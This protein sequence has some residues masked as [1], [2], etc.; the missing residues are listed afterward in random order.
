MRIQYQF[1]RGTTMAMAIAMLLG[2]CGGDKPEALL[3]SA[4]D[5]LAKND[6]KAAGIQIKNAL[7][8][9]PGLALLAS[10]DATG[11]EVELRKALDGKYPAD[12]VVPLLAQALLR[13][14]Q[15]KKL[16]SD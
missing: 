16:L 12:Q 13:S 5:Y 15:A 2:A 4:K 10:G 9:D 8:K 6:A 14:G 11:A 3:A 1:A 7:Q